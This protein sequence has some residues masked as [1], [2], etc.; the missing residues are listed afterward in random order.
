MAFTWVECR[1]FFWCRY[2]LKVP[3]TQW[4]CWSTNSNII[5]RLRR[6]TKIGCFSQKI[7]QIIR[8]IPYGC[9]S[10]CFCILCIW[11]YNLGRVASWGYRVS[12]RCCGRV[13]NFTQQRDCIKRLFTSCTWIG[14]WKQWSNGLFSYHYI[15]RY[16]CIGTCTWRWIDHFI[17]KRIYF[18]R[19]DRLCNGKIQCV[20]D[21]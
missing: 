6:C 13:F 11:F 17:F 21:Q 8:C 2:A 5:H 7:I 4:M 20:A 12:N 9:I 16:C 19:C 3:C 1:K 10:R 18:G 14:E 15:N